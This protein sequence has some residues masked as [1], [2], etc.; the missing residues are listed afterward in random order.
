MLPADL[1]ERDGHT[2]CP[3][4]T[5]TVPVSPK[6]HGKI[7]QDRYIEEIQ[8]IPEPVSRRLEHVLGKLT[9]LSIRTNSRFLNS[10]ESFS[11]ARSNATGKRPAANLEKPRSFRIGS[12][13]QKMKNE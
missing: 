9:G 1:K 12:P 7:R 8:S 10:S 11:I 4:N 5:F 13:N 6:R 3:E 2:Q